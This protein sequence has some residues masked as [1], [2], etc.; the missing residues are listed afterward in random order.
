MMQRFRD[1]SVVRRLGFLV[2]Q[3]SANYVYRRQELVSKPEHYAVYS[4]F[5]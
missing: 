5:P 3:S 2:R 1:I 4:G